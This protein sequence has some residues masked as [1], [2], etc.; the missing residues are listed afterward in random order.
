MYKRLKGQAVPPPLPLMFSFLAAILLLVGCS[1]DGIKEK[2]GLGRHSPDEF[3]ILTNEPLQ[4]PN[5]YKL[6]EPGTVRSAAS[7]RI[8]PQD[9]AKTA[10]GGVPVKSEPAVQG[11]MTAGEKGLFANI[12]A[13]DDDIREKI[14]KDGQKVNKSFISNTVAVEVVD[15]EKEAERIAAAKAK[16]EKLTGKDTPV[17]KKQEK[18]DR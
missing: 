9:Q 18:A 17:I 13:G 2:V 11:K 1:T 6:P 15:S 7:N 14:A 16:G 4:L 10:L 8:S 3:M 12:P 5:D